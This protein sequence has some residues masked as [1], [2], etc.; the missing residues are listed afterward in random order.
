VTIWPNQHTILNAMAG[1]ELSDLAD[2][3]GGGLPHAADAV[4]L[5]SA[6]SKARQQ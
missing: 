4:N 6:L 2:D 3:G 5:I 1:E